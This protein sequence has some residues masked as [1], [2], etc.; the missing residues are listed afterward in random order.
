MEAPLTVG[1]WEPPGQE[2][3]LTVIAIHGRGSNEHDLL[4]LAQPLGL[5]LRVVAPRGPLELSLGWAVGYAWYEFANL[6]DPEPQGFQQSIDRLAALVDHVR[7]RW[8]LARDQLV[9]LGFS[10]GAVMSMSVALTIPDRVGGV[11]ALSGYLPR[12]EVWQPP[13]TDLGGMPVLVTHGTYDSILPVAWGRAAAERLRQFNADVRYEEFPM[14]HEVNA[15]CLEVIRG[16][17]GGRLHGPASS[18]R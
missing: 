11:V 17:L 6:G 18:S 15:A 5:P 9:L 7:E 14:D 8:Q 13:H 3:R 2:P 4:G 1:L 16:W 10:Q 12:P